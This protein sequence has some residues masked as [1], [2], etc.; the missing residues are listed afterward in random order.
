MVDPR[1][2]ECDTCQ[3]C[4]RA[5]AE[6]YCLALGRAL[7][8]PLVVECELYLEREGLSPEVQALLARRYSGLY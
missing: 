1:W 2:L 4:R 7:D 8:S 3:N 6:R 5:A